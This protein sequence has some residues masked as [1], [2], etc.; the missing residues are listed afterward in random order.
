MQDSNLPV[1][2]SFAWASGATSTYVTTPIPGPTQTGPNVN[3][4]SQQVGFPPNTFVDPAAGGTWADGRDLNGALNMLAAVAQW[5]QA[6]GQWLYD[7]TFQTAIGGYPAGA[8]IGSAVTQG[9]FWICTTDNNTSNPDTGGAGWL[10]WGSYIASEFLAPGIY[11]YTVP[12]YCNQMWAEVWGGGGGG[13]AGA[14]ASGAG[15]G[16]AAG[17]FPVTPGQVLSIGAAAGGNG[18]GYPSAAGNGGTS[19]VV[20]GTTTILQA[21]GGIGGGPGPGVGGVGSGGQL[22]LQGGAGTDIDI[23]GS[24]QA[25]QTGMAPGGNAPRGG[26]GGSQ[27]FAGSSLVPTQPGGGGGANYNAGTGAAG[28]GGGVFIAFRVGP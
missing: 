17:W 18:Q 16:Y 6:G 7:S 19:F 10:Q 13:C 2:F 5:V 4:A 12:P 11:P 14:G 23:G 1:K 15:G 25:G 8:I 28:A 24:F 22:N 9:L 27:N 26:N 3:R 21:T 20:T